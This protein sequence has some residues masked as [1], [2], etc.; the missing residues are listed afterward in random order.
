MHCDRVDLRGLVQQAVADLNVLAEERQQSL[1]VISPDPVVASADAVVLT[2]AVVNLLHNAIKY[3]PEGA[4]I[5]VVVSAGPDPHV[6]VV[7]RGP[8]IPDAHRDKIF[9]RFYRIDQSRTRGD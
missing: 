7:D 3:S 1:R 6:D 5:D 2:Q 9:D 4:Q 8:G